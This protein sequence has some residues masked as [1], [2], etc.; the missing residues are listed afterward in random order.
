MSR[1]I[2]YINGPDSSGFITHI[3]TAGPFPKKGP[4]LSNRRALAR[5]WP[6]KDA[7][8]RYVNN[9]KIRISANGEPAPNETVATIIEV[10]A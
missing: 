10:Q 1:F 3:P 8:E 4:P 6:S 2:I 7:A 5:T 9:Y